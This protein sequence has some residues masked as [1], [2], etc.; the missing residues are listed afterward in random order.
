M[1]LAGMCF[2]HN[3]AEYFQTGTIIEDVGDVLLLE[4]DQLSD[5]NPNPPSLL[6]VRKID[7]TQSVEPEGGFGC[8]WLLFRSRQELDDYMAWL[9]AG[10]EDDPSEEEEEVS[11]QTLN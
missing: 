5:K 3:G 6:P 11:A 4:L 9:H 1:P 7:V 2:L 10:V 8:E